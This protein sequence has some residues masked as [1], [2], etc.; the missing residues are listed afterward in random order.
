M[1]HGMHK[2]LLLL[3]VTFLLSGCGGESTRIASETHTTTIG[4]ELL[5]LDRARQR[6]I[7]TEREYEQAKDDVIRRYHR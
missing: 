7:I 2:T 5:D 4:Q 6:G 1:R 3:L